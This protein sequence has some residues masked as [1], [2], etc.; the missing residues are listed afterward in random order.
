MKKKSVYLFLL[1]TC[2]LSI[3]VLFPTN[4]ANEPMGTICGS[5]YQV[6]GWQTFPIPFAHVQAGQYS[7]YA[8]VYGE[9]SLEVPLAT[10]QVTAS[11]PGFTTQTYYANLSQQNP[12][13]LHFQLQF[14]YSIDSYISASDYQQNFILYS[15]SFIELYDLLFSGQK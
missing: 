3:I 13:V 12:Y 11:K 9:Y 10:Y 7:T 4:S 8:N 14:K 15:D 5:V 2:L 1:L 6:R